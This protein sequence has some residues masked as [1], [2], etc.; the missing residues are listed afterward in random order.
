[1]W[2]EGEEIIF[3]KIPLEPCQLPKPNFYSAFYLNCTNQP[4]IR[5]KFTASVLLSAP[6]SNTVIVYIGKEKYFDKSLQRLQQICVTT[7]TN[8]KKSI[9][10]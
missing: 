4:T 5:G 3:N 2:S 10:H 9:Q 8:P 7:L 1:M 6:S